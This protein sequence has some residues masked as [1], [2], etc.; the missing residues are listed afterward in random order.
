MICALPLCLGKL[1]ILRIQTILKHS[2]IFQTFKQ[3]YYARFFT[4]KRRPFVYYLVRE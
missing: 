2:N 4:N 3:Y 1:V